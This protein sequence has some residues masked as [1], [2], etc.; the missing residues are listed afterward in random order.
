MKAIRVLFRIMKIRKI[1]NILTI[2]YQIVKVLFANTLKYI[3]FYL[4]KI[5]GHQK[6][7]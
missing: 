5:I 6:S 4:S 3:A 7:Q 2:V 1:I